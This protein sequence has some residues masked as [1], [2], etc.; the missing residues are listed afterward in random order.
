MSTFS[1]A[2][3]KLSPSPPVTLSSCVWKSSGRLTARQ[4][5]NP[6]VESIVNAVPYTKSYPNMA[7]TALSS[8][9]FRD[10]LVLLGDAAHAHGGAFGAGG[11]LA[12]NDAYALAL[13]LAHVWPPGSGGVLSARP[14]TQQLHKALSLYEETRKPLVTRLLNIVHGNAQARRWAADKRKDGGEETEAELRTRIANRPDMSWLSE[15]DVEA[16]FRAVVGR[17]ST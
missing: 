4:G 9:C 10:R 11:S 3:T 17:Y 16:E 13:A 2:S 1:R 12:I 8:F 7:G 5:W 15:H 6:V 14:T